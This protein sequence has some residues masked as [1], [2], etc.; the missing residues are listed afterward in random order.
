[1]EKRYVIKNTEN[2]KY[3]TGSYDCFWSLDIKDAETYLAYPYPA[4]PYSSMD[5][6][7]NKIIKE[8]D[9]ENGSGAFENVNCIIIETIY[10]LK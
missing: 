2:G 8:T 5:L 6:V 9:E 4:C 7:E 3:Y 10:K 1:M